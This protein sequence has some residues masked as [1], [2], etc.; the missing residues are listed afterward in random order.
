[1]RKKYL[2]A[3]LFGALLFASAGTF[4]SCKDY[5]DDINNLQTQV[6]DVKNAVAELQK[7]IGDGKFVTNIVSE[8][9]GLKITWN[10][11]QSTVIE[12]V[13]NE[14]NQEVTPG[15][16]VTFDEVTGE[17]LINGK[18][19][20]YYT[21][22]KQLV[23]EDAQLPYVND[24]GYLVIFDETGKE[25]TTDIKASPV[26]AVKNE[27]GSY[28]L[29]IWA[30]GSKQTVEVPSAASSLT[31]ITIA[32]D[33]NEAVD[34]KVRTNIQ[35]NLADN[36]SYRKDWNGAKTLPKAGSYII[37]NHQSS[38][39]LQIRVN[40]INVDASLV[41]FKLTDSK[42]NDLEGIT[43]SAKAENTTLTTTGGPDG[44][45]ADKG[46]L[47][48]LSLNDLIVEDKEAVESVVEEFKNGSVL[49]ALNPNSNVRSAYKITVNETEDALEGTKVELYEGTTPKTENTKVPTDETV[50]PVT[51][52]VDKGATYTFK[53]DGN[54]MYDLMMI[55][56]DEAK[57]NYKL[58]LDPATY[59][60]TIGR[61]IDV[62]TSGTF[63]MKVIIVEVNGQVKVRNYT[64]NLSDKISDATSYEEVPYAVTSNDKVFGIDLST[65]K[66]GMTAEELNTW[67]TRVDFKNTEYTLWE[68]VQ[69]GDVAGKEY[70]SSAITNKL[71][72]PYVTKTIDKNAK[73]N[74]SSKDEANYI[75]IKVDDSKANPDIKLFTTYYLKVTFKSSNSS[76]GELNS[77]IVPVKFTAP[78][79]AEQFSVKSGLEKDGVVYG[80][81]S[82]TFDFKN[83][84]SETKEQV[85]PAFAINEAFKDHAKGATYSVTTDLID[86]MDNVKSSDRF[87]INNAEDD[88]TVDSYVPYVGFKQ[89]V[90]GKD[91][92]QDAYAK[93][94]TLKAYSATYDK[95]I[96]PT[97]SKYTDYKFKMTLM[98]P[99]Y[100]G[101]FAEGTTLT[102]NGGQDFKFTNDQ[103]KFSDYNNT[104]VK[105]LQDAYDS[106]N[107]EGV[108]SDT[109]ISDVEAGDD[110]QMLNNEGKLGVIKATWDA[111]A[112]KVVE[113][114]I[115][116]KAA[117]VA[118]DG[119]ENL[120]III[121]D[122]MGYQRTFKI[123]VTIKA[124]K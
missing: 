8:N 64:F 44:R 17:I 105:I 39:P 32:G 41:T 100:D 59:S 53:D 68:K 13:I 77:I 5:D 123:P 119:T 35:F 48:T 116:G 95:W 94:F 16:V 7:L 107:K 47:Y 26:T 11:G 102:V 111:T 113:G 115:T 106:E 30:N 9:N 10:D 70:T 29:T 56:D 54:K 28:T 75:S 3:L 66:N 124:N 55:V 79:V 67:K 37:R 108:W 65:M 25:V 24:N 22:K 90:P 110:N 76:N 58:E 52:K 21:S 2:S 98:S 60:F 104:P 103:L 74:V 92:T 14:E 12:N 63:T 57:N 4:T 112:N 118:V 49:F 88:I 61:D 120:H 99:I 23:E 18:G 46:G 78:T 117:S 86:G 33:Y 91:K 89:G 114:Y 45:A 81:M 72:T 121:K 73:A 87:I 34:L 38:D 15:D 85:R 42:N 69:N 20:G 83:I 122:N 97:D 51:V 50:T 101:S 62:S 19:T 40:P 6:T 109:R 82:G 84:L 80:F 27:D 71:L 96:Y 31:S 43:L 93:A 36:S 1:M